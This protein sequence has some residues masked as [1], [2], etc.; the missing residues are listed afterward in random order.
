MFSGRRVECIK[1]GDEFGSVKPGTQGT[2]IMGP[3]SMKQIL[4]DWDDESS[5]MLIDGV[6][7]YKFL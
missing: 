2:I 3:N 4:V 7:Q 5:L 1:C 6:D